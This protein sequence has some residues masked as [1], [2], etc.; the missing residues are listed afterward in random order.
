VYP[1]GSMLLLFGGCAAL[2]SLAFAASYLGPEPE[3]LAVPAVS[4]T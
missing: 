4:Q 3:P 2:A 1:T